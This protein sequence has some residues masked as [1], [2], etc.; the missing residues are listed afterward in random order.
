MAPQ[1]LFA[2]QG[3]LSPDDTPVLYHAALK[4][5]ENP[6]YVLIR[7]KTKRDETVLSNQSHRSHGAKI[8]NTSN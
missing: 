1:T 7:K 5:S 6:I 2:K 8:S 4:K 3:G